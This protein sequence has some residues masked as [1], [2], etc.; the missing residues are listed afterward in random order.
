MTDG[1]K[2]LEQFLLRKWMI[3]ADFCGIHEHRVRN[4]TRV[5]FRLLLLILSSIQ[6]LFCSSTVIL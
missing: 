5:H 2:R 3:S 1:S 4:Q 6:F